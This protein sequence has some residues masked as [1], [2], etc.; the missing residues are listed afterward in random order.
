MRRQQ[1][2]RIGELWGDFLAGAP[3]IARKIAEAKVEQVWPAVA[4]PRIAAYTT[5]VKVV[6]GAAHVSIASAPARSE[7]FAD[8]MRM[9]EEINRLLGMDVVRTIIIK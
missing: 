8:R 7:A 5:S 1:P 4:G 9:K 3:G 6:H 2:V